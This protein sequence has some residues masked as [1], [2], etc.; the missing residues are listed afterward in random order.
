MLP[1]SAI[2]GSAGRTLIALRE[3]VGESGTYALAVGDEFRT[4]PA[5]GRARPPAPRTRTTCRRR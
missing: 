1:A 4:I 3:A 2:E 5:A